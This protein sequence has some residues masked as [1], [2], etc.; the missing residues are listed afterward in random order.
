MV[1]NIAVNYSL[2]QDIFELIQTGSLPSYNL[3][4]GNGNGN[5]SCHIH[6]RTIKQSKKTE[7]E[8]RKN[9]NQ[10]KEVEEMDLNA[11][12]IDRINSLKREYLESAESLLLN[13]IQVLLKILEFQSL[14]LKYE[15]RLISSPESES[16]VAILQKYKERF[17]HRNA[18]SKYQLILPLMSFLF[19]NHRS[20]KSVYETSLCFMEKSRMHLREGDFAKTKTGVQRFLTNTK[21]AAL[22]L[23][24]FGL[25]RSDSRHYFKKWELSLFGVLIAGKIYYDY[26]DNLS[27]LFLMHDHNNEGFYLKFLDLLMRYLEELQDRKKYCCFLRQIF[28]DEVVCSYFALND[29]KFSEFFNLIC[30]AISKGYNPKEQATR[31]FVSFL[32]RINAD[33][34]ISRLAEAIVLKKDTD[35]NMGDV[36]TILNGY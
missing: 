16:R 17:S 30:V 25:L 32:N 27:K 9:G 20:H 19:I 18:Y 24:K 13:E 34:E 31:D 6:R 10:I 26:K 11:Q 23:R 33:K 4:N 1:N 29:Q 7:T 28:E 3:K 22:E 2:S 21:F 8:S 15:L 12:I 35:V 36:F 14:E 5:G